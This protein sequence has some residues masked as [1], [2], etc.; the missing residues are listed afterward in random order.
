MTEKNS[1]TKSKIRKFGFSTLFILHPKQPLRP[2]QVLVNPL[3]LLYFVVVLLLLFVVVPPP[4]SAV[5]PAG[6]R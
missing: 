2:F 4:G 3:V 5:G 1:S 6:H